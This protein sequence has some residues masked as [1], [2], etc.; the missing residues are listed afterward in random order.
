MLVFFSCDISR[1]EDE[2]LDTE[3]K[4][5]LYRVNLYPNDDN[6]SMSDQNNI[7][8]EAHIRI[9][10]GKMTVNPSFDDIFGFKN[11]IAP[12][13]V[14]GNFDFSVKLNGES[15]KPDKWKYIQYAIE[16]ETK[17][18]GL[19]MVTHLT[20]AIDEPV[21]VQSAEIFNE[22]KDKKSF[23][24]SV[25]MKGFFSKPSPEEW[26]F[27]GPAPNYP[28]AFSYNRNKRLLSSRSNDGG[29]YC[30]SSIP[31]AEYSDGA[32]KASFLVDS[33]QFARFHF[34]CTEGTSEESLARLKK[35]L[36]TA[37]NDFFNETRTITKRNYF[38]K[39]KEYPW[40][41]STDYKLTMFYNRSV[42][43]LM[44][45]SWSVPGVLVSDP[46]FATGG[47]DG[48]ALCSYLWDYAY[49]DKM[50]IL[51]DRNVAKRYIRF[52]YN[53]GID[54]HYAFTPVM[55]KSIGPR[56]A[57]NDYSFVKIVYD[58]IC[59]TGDWSILEMQ[60]S[61][62]KLIDFLIEL[63]DRGVATGEMPD[64]IDYG[65]NENLLEL[66]KT[67]YEHYV[68]SP[69]AERVWVYRAVAEILEEMGDPGGIAS[70]YRKK[71]AHLANLINEKL[72]NPVKG[73]Y[74]LID[75]DG[76]KKTV[77]SVQI[78]DM[79]K[80]GVPDQA[81]IDILMRHLNEREFLGEYGVR[82]LSKWDPGFDESDVDWGGPG[83]YIGDAPELITD[84][85][86]VG[87]VKEAEN[88]LFRILWWGTDLT[89]LPQAVYADRKDYR[90]NGRPNSIGG[91]VGA[92]SIIEGMF[93][94]RV[95][96]NGEISILPRPLA[97]SERTAIKNL[98]IRGNSFDIVI[99]PDVC[100]YSINDSPQRKV[101][102]NE[103][104]II[105]KGDNLRYQEPRPAQKCP[106]KK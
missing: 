82:S 18:D 61:G 44:N 52:F 66:K 8:D 53:M 64:L 20:L 79:L 67:K 26:D 45:S 56:Y 73:W 5:K 22:T 9:F 69:N 60:K 27:G 48:G 19:W 58:Y 31:D 62:K 36:N 25:F 106:G 100:K 10:N 1:C 65:T 49:S 3:M 17:K 97:T 102:I 70:R 2:T 90:H 99:K 84:L 12:P 76:N 87:K 81:K 75:S 103:R 104:S 101:P 7:F 16:R 83:T 15:I 63:A 55:A 91:L 30:V 71:A 34:Y 21:F 38:Y 33:M 86:R 14:T 94:L 92:Q 47:L 43:S 32:L 37:P 89:Y 35:Y 23:D 88:I 98:I 42:Y 46:Y 57:Y 68:P 29:V 50:L 28:S 72:W 40:L 80:T 74:D 95:G 77:W 41:Q 54:E 13:Y 78:F 6:F 93:G 11:P 96:L 59:L 39:F 85:Y 4:A 105:F 24:I 51:A